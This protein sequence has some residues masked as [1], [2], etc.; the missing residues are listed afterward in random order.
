MGEI[1][2]GCTA[3]TRANLSD[4]RGTYVR[5]PWPMPS[6][7]DRSG[8]A[9]MLELMGP[10]HDEDHNARVSH[11]ARWG[12]QPNRTTRTIKYS[13]S[14]GYFEVSPRPTNFPLEVAR[15]GVTLAEPRRGA[16][17]P[18]G[19]SSL[20]SVS[21]VVRTPAW[22]CTRRPSWTPRRTGTDEASTYLEEWLRAM[23]DE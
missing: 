6:P 18:S 1:A 19:H 21:S 4:V 11:D 13:V 12:R 20:K 5:G 2:F 15:E 10:N 16:A 23:N 17:G 9:G 8:R 7:K 22:R 14:S 3:R